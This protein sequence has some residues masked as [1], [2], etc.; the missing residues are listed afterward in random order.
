MISAVFLAALFCFVSCGPDV[1][2]MLV[3]M[4]YPSSS[5]ID[6]SGKSIAV[7]YMDDS[8]RD[9]VFSS[10]LAEGF[11]KSLEDDYFSGEE[12]V[13]IF[14]MTKDSSGV[15]SSKDSLVNAAM[16][17]GGD[18]VFLF[19]SPSFG[20][21]SVT[22]SRSFG[23]STSVTV[24]MPFKLNL[25]AYNTLGQDS[26]RTF[27]GTSSVVSSFECVKDAPA[28]TVSQKFWNSL[29]QAGEVTGS[30][31]SSKFLSTWEPEIY[32]FYF[33][34]SPSAW[35]SASQAAYEYRWRDAVDGW[36]TL[37][38]TNDMYRRSAAEFNIAEA[39]Y[40]LGDYSLATSWLDQSD[41]DCKMDHS[42]YLRRKIEGRSRMEKR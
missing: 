15:Y 2:S 19:D 7:V 39:F 35:N 26:V 40:L 9:S 38:E 25:Y 42:S 33:Y 16:Q 1:F 22:E 30:R 34:D 13:G 31:S 3:E 36:M 10:S 4:R 12:A 32:Y 6:L 41:K 17:T 23:D 37:L 24:T 29:S 8:S 28:D 20:E 5:G 21:A 14:K 18:V 11:A 27:K